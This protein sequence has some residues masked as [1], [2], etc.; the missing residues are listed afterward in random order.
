MAGNVKE[1]CF[2]EAPDGC[3]VIAGGAWNEPEYLFKG[4]DKYPPFFR[5]ANFGFRCMKALAE[6][7]YRS[8]PPTATKG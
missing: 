7:E 1:W 2:N 6:K 4:G 8:T 5:E 3:R